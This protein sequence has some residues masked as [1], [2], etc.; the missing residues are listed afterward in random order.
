[1]SCALLSLFFYPRLRP[2]GATVVIESGGGATLILPLSTDQILPVSGPLG[3]TVV[4]VRDGRVGVQHS[5]CPHK[6][7]VQMGFRDRA[8]DMI[9]CIP[10]K[11]VVRIMGRGRE[12]EVDGITR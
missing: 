12:E 3:E 2:Q 1:M 4:E 9:V 11:V 8:G 7:C 6:R 10:N 5:P